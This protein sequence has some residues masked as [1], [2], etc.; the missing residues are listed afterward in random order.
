MSILAKSPTFSQL[1]EPPITRTITPASD[2]DA[3]LPYFV[4]SI[5]LSFPCIA[6]ALSAI[7]ASTF[8]PGAEAEAQHGYG[9]L[10]TAICTHPNLY[11]SWIPQD[12][13]LQHFQDRSPL[14]TST[15]MPRHPTTLP[16]HDTSSFEKYQ[17]WFRGRH[18]LV[19]S[20]F[21]N[22]NHPYKPEYI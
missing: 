6:R 17:S 7:G 13:H 5:A 16:H 18:V 3:F 8:S 1:K 22:L 19:A 11:N 10:S 9:R 21:Q 20:T 14:T 2:R 15:S 4:T 12:I